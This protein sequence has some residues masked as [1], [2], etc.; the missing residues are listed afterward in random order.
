[1]TYRAGEL[2]QL[3]TIKREVRTSDGMGGDTVTL[4]D[5]AADL[6]AHVRPRS[7]KEIGTHDRVEA[8]A[9]YLFVIRYRSDLK[10]SDRIVWNGATYNIRYIATRGYRSMYMEIEAERGVT[11]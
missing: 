8:P 1:M 6:F 2:D 5:V 3:I 7:G 10:D 11:Q 4:T 9:K